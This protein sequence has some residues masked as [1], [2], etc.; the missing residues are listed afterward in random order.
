MSK[1]CSGLNAQFTAR[2]VVLVTCL[3]AFTLAGCERKERVIDVHAPG[4]DV[5]VDKNVDT[6]KVEVEA[7]KK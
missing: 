5:K 3:G 1:L 6:G 4:V 7:T 2:L